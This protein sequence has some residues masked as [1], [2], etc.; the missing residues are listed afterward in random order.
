MAPGMRDHCRW[1]GGARR[2]AVWAC[3][4]GVEPR[5][6][7]WACVIHTDW[8]SFTVKSSREPLQLCRALFKDARV[9]VNIVGH[10]GSRGWAAEGA[11]SIRLALLWTLYQI[12]GKAP[13]GR[14]RLVKTRALGPGDSSG[15]LVAF[16][17]PVPEC[18]TRAG[19]VMSEEGE[20]GTAGAAGAALS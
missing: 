11:A 9:E 18:E 17:T 7:L 10:L 1:R 20:P 15:D 12:A 16:R 2:R 19:V 5:G 3:H 13:V 6:S 14:W 8:C 4:S